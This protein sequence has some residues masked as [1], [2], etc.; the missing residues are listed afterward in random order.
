MLMRGVWP[1]NDVFSGVSELMKCA[2]LYV[3]S[4]NGRLKGCLGTLDMK[5]QLNCNM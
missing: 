1:S 3:I 2:L 4:S 5:V